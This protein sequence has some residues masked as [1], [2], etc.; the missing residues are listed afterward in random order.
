MKKIQKGEGV[1]RF[2]KRSRIMNNKK[3]GQ[4]WLGQQGQLFLL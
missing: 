2:S 3:Q 4:L 1:L